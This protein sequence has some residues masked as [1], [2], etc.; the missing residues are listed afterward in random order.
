MNSSW[1]FVAD[2]GELIEE[3]KSYVH[4]LYEFIYYM[5]PF[6]IRMHL[7]DEFTDNISVVY[8]FID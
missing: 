2:A 8:M 1:I 5:N 4:R 7:L 3:M 6:I